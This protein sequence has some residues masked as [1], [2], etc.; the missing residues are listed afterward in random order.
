M[1]IS[2]AERFRDG[3]AQRSDPPLAGASLYRAKI[4]RVKEGGLVRR[5]GGS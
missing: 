3:L 1:D 4:V 5:L 2:L